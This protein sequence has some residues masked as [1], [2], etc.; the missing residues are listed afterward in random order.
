M[1]KWTVGDVVRL[2]SGGPSMTIVQVLEDGWLLVLW[3]KD[4]ERHTDL[5]PPEAVFQP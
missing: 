1:K 4:A 2:K 5:L 3:F